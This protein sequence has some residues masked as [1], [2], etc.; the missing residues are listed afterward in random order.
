MYSQNAD[1]NIF[2]HFFFWNIFSLWRHETATIYVLVSYGVRFVQFIA[3]IL[4]NG[5]AS[6][7]VT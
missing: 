6:A 5:A 4:N 3:F 7:I 1:N 2:I